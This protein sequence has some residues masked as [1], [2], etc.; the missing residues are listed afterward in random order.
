MALLSF[1]K[2]LALIHLLLLPHPPRLRGKLSQ[3]LHTTSPVH[4]YTNISFYPSFIFVR[5]YCLYLLCIKCTGTACI[6]GVQ[7]MVQEADLKLCNIHVRKIT[8]YYYCIFSIFENW[9]IFFPQQCSWYLQII[10]RSCES[11]VSHLT[12]RISGFN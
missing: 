4:G 11:D 7:V 1:C 5:Q 12:Y 9:I 8:F 2:K 3:S 10:S 6:W